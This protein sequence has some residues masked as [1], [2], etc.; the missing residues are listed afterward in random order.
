M[1]TPRL[2][3]IKLNKIILKLIKEKHRNKMSEDILKKTRYVDLLYL[4]N[5]GSR[6]WPIYVWELITFR[7]TKEKSTVQ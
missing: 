3:F 7:I 4:V 1:N 2:I 5:K 6:N